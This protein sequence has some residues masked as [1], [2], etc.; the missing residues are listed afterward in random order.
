MSAW[1]EE[2]R[3]RLEE[4][5]EG[6]AARLSASLAS[7]LECIDFAP[8]RLEAALYDETAARALRVLAALDEPAR[9]VPLGHV[10][11]QALDR[12]AVRVPFALE[13]SCAAGTRSASR[14]VDATHATVLEEVLVGIA[15]LAGEGGTLQIDLAAGELQVSWSATASSRAGSLLSTLL[16]SYGSQLLD[17]GG[18]LVLAMGDFVSR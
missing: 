5:V 13:L 1:R 17:G 14:T 2:L 18:V 8:E 7:G 3:G 10:L 15:E 9:P 12:V 4:L 16:A 11:T 6:A